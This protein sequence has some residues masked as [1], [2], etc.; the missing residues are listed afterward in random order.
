MA[1]YLPPASVAA[2][3]IE[4]AHAAMLAAV[5]RLRG[6]LEREARAD[7]RPLCNDAAGALESL[8]A[9]RLSG[10]A[11]DVADAADEL[12]RGGTY[13]RE[14]ARRQQFARVAA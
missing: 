14:D 12:R 9:L 5:A 11:Q 3:Q 1:H 13:W 7:A 2:D 4:A 6:L 10:L 8:N